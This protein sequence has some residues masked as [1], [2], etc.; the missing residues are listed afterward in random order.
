MPNSVSLPFNN[1]RKSHQKYKYETLVTDREEIKLILLKALGND[2]A[3]LQQVLSGQLSV[4]NSC[5]SGMT[6]AVIWLALQELG[7]HSS[8]YDEVSL[9]AA[10]FERQHQH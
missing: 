8:I 5:G 7:I 6:A 3:K 2:E 1:L 10:P 4:I 9:V